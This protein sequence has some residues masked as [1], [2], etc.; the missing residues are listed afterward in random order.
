LNKIKFFSFQLWQKFTEAHELLSQIEAL[1]A[2]FPDK[3]DF[4]GAVNGLVVLYDTYLPNPVEMSQGKIT[5][6]SPL[7]NGDVSKTCPKC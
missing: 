3:E 4:T 6:R 2:P 5:L 1:Q 7:P